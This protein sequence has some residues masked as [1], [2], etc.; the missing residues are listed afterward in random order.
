MKMQKNAPLRKE[1]AIEEILERLVCGE[2]LTRIC[3]DEH[4]ANEGTVYRWLA[5][6]EE[7]SQ[8]YSR[9]RALQADTFADQIVEIA[10]TEKDAQKARNR[11]DARKWAA[12]KLAPKKYGDTKDVHLTGSVDFRPRVIDLRPDKDQDE[13]PLLPGE[14][15]KQ[16][17]PSDNQ[18][19]SEP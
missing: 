18:R 15:A 8:R 12:S 11:I 13:H 10:D 16:G 5:A 6:S 9:A 3:R 19:E 1:R 4:L 17:I 2:P 7:L 14:P